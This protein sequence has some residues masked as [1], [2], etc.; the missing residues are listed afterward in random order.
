[1]SGELVSFRGEKLNEERR[2]GGG[3]ESRGRCC[4]QKYGLNKNQNEGES[5]YSKS[6]G[7]TGR[8]E[9][10][11]KVYKG[12]EEEAEGGGGAG[13]KYGVITRRREWSRKVDLTD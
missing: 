4:Y 12:K 2:G 7:R 6:E 1:M 8:Y 9:G 13:D 5:D 11:G 3:E 10:G